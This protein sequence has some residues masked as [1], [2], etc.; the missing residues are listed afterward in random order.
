M[1]IESFKEILRRQRASGLP[2]RDFCINEGLTKSTFYY[3]LRKVTDFD[4]QPKEFIPL[5]MTD[6]FPAT[7]KEPVSKKMFQPMQDPIQN[8]ASLEFVFPNG[9]RLL[10]GD[11]VDLALLQTIAHLYD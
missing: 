3:W 6:T 9:T 2:V 8:G 10:V 4:G 5:L 1:N 7:R 11:K